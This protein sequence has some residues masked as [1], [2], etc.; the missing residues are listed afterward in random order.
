M[1]IF[2]RPTADPLSDQALTA[3][4][5]SAVITIQSEASRILRA[6]LRRYC[7]G[8]TQGR[9]F[10]VAGHRGSGKTTMVGDAIARVSRAL[11]GK[12]GA[13]RPLP[14]FLHGPSLFDSRPSEDEPPAAPTAE[15]VSATME[16]TATMQAAVAHVM[17]AVQKASSKG[18][19]TPA[20]RASVRKKALADFRAAQAATTPEETEQETEDGKNAGKEPDPALEVEELAKRAMV[21]VI[22]GLHRAVAKEFSNAFRRRAIARTPR[23]GS[24]AQ[25]RTD[26]AELAAQFEIE[27]LEDPHAVR[28]REFWDHVGALDGGVLF[29]GTR[30]QG[31]GARELVALNGICNA[32]QRISGDI[33]ER[34]ER[35]R[36]ESSSSE[37]TSG[38]NVKMVDALK[39]V[40]S[41]LA[42]S[43]VAGGAAA[44]GSHSLITSVMLGIVVALFSSIT[45][46]RTSRWN[47]KQE[48]QLDKVFIP[49][50]SLRTL[51]RVLPMLLDRLRLAGLA[52]VLVIDELDKVSDLANRIYGMVRCLKK[53]MAENVLSCFLTDRSYLEYLRI[54]GGEKAYGL[55]YSYFSHALLIAHQPSDI[56]TFLT[57]LLEI[58]T[59]PGD[60]VA[61]ADLPPV[62]YDQ[63]DADVLKW[64]LRHRSQLHALALSRELAGIRGESGAVQIAQGVVR[65]AYMYRIDATLQVAIELQ[66]SSPDLM[67]WLAQ[68][69]GMMQTLTD[70]LYYLSRH[71]ISGKQERVDLAGEGAKAFETYLRDRMNLD[72]VRICKPNDNGQP[73]ALE[74]PAL[75]PNDVRKLLEVVEDVATFLCESNTLENV[76]AAWA[77]VAS[78][79]FGMAPVSMPEQTVFDALLL[80]SDSL[81][82][83]EPQALGGKAYRWR[84]GSAGETRD[85]GGTVRDP[86]AMRRDARRSAEFIRK[87]EK[88][89]NSAFTPEGV[90]E[91]PRGAVF[92]LLAERVR[93]L[94]TTPA[95]TR[96]ESAMANLDLIDRGLGNTASFDD[97]CRAL[98]GFETMLRANSATIEC[99]LRN[100]AFLI[101]L[102][103]DVPVHNSLRTGLRVLC[104]GLLFSTI[105]STEVATALR[106]FQDA[107]DQR[108]G[109]DAVMTRD[110]DAPPVDLETY[111]FRLAVTTAWTAGR[112]QKAKVDR[113]ALVGEAWD[114]LYVRLL[115]LA[116][117]D[118]ERAA[119]PSELLCAAFGVGPIATIGLQL[120]A[121]TL[122]MWTTALLRSI[123]SSDNTEL[124]R[125]PLWM[126]PLCLRSLGFQ[127]DFGNPDSLGAF[128]SHVS[129]LRGVAAAELNRA[130]AIIQSGILRG[131]ESKG[132]YRSAMVVRRSRNSFMN[133]WSQR[134]THGLILL[135]KP[136][137]VEAASALSPLFWTN[138]ALPTLLVGWEQPPDSSAEELALRAKMPGL[139]VPKES[140]FV[141][142][143][144]V[145]GMQAPAII[146]PKG[147]DDILDYTPSTATTR[148]AS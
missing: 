12:P 60:E 52:P 106:E 81:L 34:D 145:L 7:E 103:N 86:E 82:V 80:G 44:S 89:I 74:P 45:L 126:G 108:L 139:D 85:F 22:L 125:V 88:N 100:A 144:T 32:H 129:Q 46:T 6:E 138:T 65:T 58:P 104:T 63:L 78:K 123:A 28:L 27:L 79:R 15:Q 50:L 11:A 135:V 35:K 66:L 122:S 4:S 59:G 116:R 21:Q 114:A 97:D 147:P 131:G 57:E 84:Y 43:A 73:R 31:Q 67:S 30:T 141:Y 136:G 91:D 87:V 29:D 51:D 47:R 14:V 118:A 72:E 39:P 98:A 140:V 128:L 40:A 9:S 38:F 102:G 124:D 26:A 142:P 19:L 115:D 54:H 37:T 133:A 64:I 69:P 1:A 68:R 55:T 96:V 56:D 127:I 143:G 107:L 83:R 25:Q 101:G 92:R 49:D 77:N 132:R 36:G 137:E 8:E 53:L 23:E 117:T 75:S 76:K 61:A 42:G 70:A 41:L 119:E 20:E 5:E 146:A 93:A 120:R 130:L 2:I 62:A 110:E 10:L 16:K 105:D 109:G 112:D 18:R 24:S 17:Q 33:K 71:W 121:T 90:D 94:P 134:P 48:R 3:P 148:T 99:L 95:W 111:G 113:K 13:M